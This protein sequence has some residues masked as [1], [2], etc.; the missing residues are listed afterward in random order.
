MES[1]AFFRL[2]AGV[3]PCT[4]LQL[5]QGDLEG[6]SQQLTM[7]V[8]QAPEF[9]RGVPVVIDLERLHSDEPPDFAGLK[10]LLLSSGLIPVGV[11]HA[12]DLQREAA[13]LEGLP[14][15]AAG[16]LQESSE[17][18][19]E[20]DVRHAPTRMV[21][22]PVR[23]GTQIYAKEADLVVIASVS[24]GAELLA[25]GNIHVYGPLRGRA[26]AG[27]QGNRS[28]RIFCTTLEAELVSIA[29]YYLTQEDMQA[30]LPNHDMIQV[31]LEGDEL[32]VEPVCQS[33]F[34]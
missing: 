34:A 31:Y 24:P 22:T 29:G 25:D 4:V 33:H 27:V 9:F 26:L 3:A 14:L 13:L 28:A 19:T 18:K 20:K 23:S 8:Q 21:T 32:R 11:R 30:L 10:S 12:S 5:M 7:T 2:K 15:L 6:I 16:K 17:K 1:Q